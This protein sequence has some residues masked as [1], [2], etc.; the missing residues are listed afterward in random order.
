[1]AIKNVI[2]VGAG[3]TL[4]D[5]IKKPLNKR[6][7]L[8]KKFFSNV[9]ISD[10]T[11]LRTII[12]YLK[13]YYGF[14]PLEA[15]RDSLESVMAIIYAD[16]HHID[17]G[18]DALNA[19]LSLIKI[20]NERIAATTNNLN[21]TI[22][23][24]IYR[25]LS[26]YLDKKISPSEI[27]LITFNQDIQLEK[28]LEKLHSKRSKKVGRIF[29]FPYCY[30]LAD[31]SKRITTPESARTFKM[32]KRKD[33]GICVLKLHGSLNWFSLHKRPDIP[34]N[35][36]LSKK[37]K[38]RITRRKSISV[39]M[40][41][42]SR[43]IRYYTLPL[44][45]PPVSHKAGI[46]NNDLNEIWKEAEKA[47]N[48]AENVLIFGYSCPENDFESANLIRRAFIKNKNLKEI[49]IIDPNPSISKR[50][51]DLTEIDIIHYHKSIDAFLIK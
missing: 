9:N 28:I 30:K 3:C 5:A 24:G 49:S 11:K 2:I 4:N 19:F 10:P 42:R 39:D 35:S 12:D 20:F 45:I 15:E 21:P 6:P 13:K 1:M 37:K 18:A 46:L 22:E 41:Y 17:L 29:N 44:V 8:D 50:Y 38:F 25:I 43:T 16:I 48:E 7:P 33:I 32:G 26:R 40:R 23:F 27:C 14:N 34:K 47:L 31:Y 36:I 51:A